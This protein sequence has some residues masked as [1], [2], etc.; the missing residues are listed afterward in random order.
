ME[1]RLWQDLLWDNDNQVNTDAL[2]QICFAIPED[3]RRS[4]VCYLQEL[5]E[6]LTA[7]NVP[8]SVI[9]EQIIYELTGKGSSPVDLAS[10]CTGDERHT[11]AT[12]NTDAAHDESC[13]DRRHRHRTRT[14]HQDWSPSRPAVMPSH[15]RILRRL[16]TSMTTAC[17]L[18]TRT[19]TTYWRRLTYR[20]STELAKLQRLRLNPVTSE[21]AMYGR[22]LALINQYLPPAARNGWIVVEHYDERSNRLFPSAVYPP[23]DDPD[24][25]ASLSQSLTYE[26][27]DPYCEGV[28]PKCARNALIWRSSTTYPSPIIVDDVRRS[29]E[30]RLIDPQTRS[31]VAVPV[32]WGGRLLAVLHFES[33][34]RRAFRNAEPLLNG[35][36]RTLERFYALYEASAIGCTHSIEQLLHLDMDPASNL[37]HLLKLVCRIAAGAVNPPAIAAYL[38]IWDGKGFSRDLRAWSIGELGV[39]L[40][41]YLRDLQLRPDGLSES[42]LETKTPVFGLRSHG[43][44]SADGLL[45]DETLQYMLA[46]PTVGTK[47]KANRSCSVLPLFSQGVPVGVLWLL[48]ERGRTGTVTPSEQT[49][50]SCVANLAGSLVGEP[51]LHRRKSDPAPLDVTATGCNRG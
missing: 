16:L 5:V 39:F 44:T 42:V 43:R 46:A 31:E 6:D 23:F 25:Y 34:S 15:G 2:W 49:H 22:A 29:G 32:F 18:M 10:L 47:A 12:G 1:V 41:S 11:N 30:Y 33:R 13:R 21:A 50:L 40:T 19:T 9:V 24:M 20:Q 28:V 37:R 8:R 3:E 51:V 48:F 35:I 27:N 45:C 26:L 14:E 36:V 7:H 17:E 38:G 4:C